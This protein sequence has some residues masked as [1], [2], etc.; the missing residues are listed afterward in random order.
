MHLVAELCSFREEVKKK[1]SGNQIAGSVE[2]WSMTLDD[3]VAHMTVI[4]IP[5]DY[6]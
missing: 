4:L 2:A 3:A 6:R 1:Q 5:I